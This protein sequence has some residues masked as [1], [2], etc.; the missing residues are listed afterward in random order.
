MNKKNCSIALF[1][2][3]I[4]A[5]PSCA[6][7]GASSGTSPRTPFLGGV[8]GVRV[9]FEKESPPAEVIGDNS[10]EFKTVLRLTNSGEFDINP[11]DIRVNLE[12][13]SAFVSDDSIITD[14]K[15]DDGGKV[16]SARKRNA[17][18][19]SVDGDT[20]FATLPKD[21]YMRP[22]N[23]GSG[24]YTFIAKIC[25][26]YQT[27]ANARLC[28]LNDML[29]TKS[30]ICSMGEKTT[31]SSSAPVQIT[32][33]EQVAI[34][35]DQSRFSFDVVLSDN[36]RIFKDKNNPEITPSVG[37]NQA[38]ALNAPANSLEDNVKVQVSTASP[39]D[40]IVQ[41]LSCFPATPGTFSNSAVVTLINGK[42]SVT[43]YAEIGQQRSDLEKIIEIK[44]WYNVYDERSQASFRVD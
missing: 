14:Q 5:L 9:E 10:Y 42:A 39:F 17:E 19:N 6:R 15:L 44:V 40:Q 1:L 32:N 25:Y 21:D 2:F 12:G 35:K 20:R 11:D 30:K 24:D 36:V 43:C 37:F 26:A 27:I 33:F 23:L 22:P 8:S 16:F 28:I 13:A 31:Y 34:G 18:G 3:L 29:N 38:C 41:G 4:V 7:S